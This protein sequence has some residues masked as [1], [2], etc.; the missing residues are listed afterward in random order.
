LADIEN[1]AGARETSGLD[2]GRKHAEQV[3]VEG[4]NLSLLAYSELVFSIFDPVTHI[5][6]SLKGL[7]RVGS[8]RSFCQFQPA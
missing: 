5:S 4:H 8:N 7:S 3:K 1:L 2:H 6:F